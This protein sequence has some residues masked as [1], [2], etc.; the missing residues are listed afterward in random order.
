MKDC[1]KSLDS[2]CYKR[3]L[4]QFTRR[5]VISC[6]KEQERRRMN[7]TL[8]VDPALKNSVLLFSALLILLHVIRPRILFDEQ[9][10]RPR[11][12][13][14]GYNRDSQKRTLFS[15]ST[16]IPAL[17]CLCWVTVADI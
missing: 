4:T 5:I 7:L 6:F 1:N 2:C 10:G 13:G 17:A 12:F 11:P 14:L 3:L 9:T 15:M 16:I 8:A